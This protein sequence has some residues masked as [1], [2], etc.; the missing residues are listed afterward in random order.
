M[1][2]NLIVSTKEGTS[3]KT[4]D[5]GGRYKVGKIFFDFAVTHMQDKYLFQIA[6]RVVAIG[7]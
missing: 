5:N 1:A 6:L 7:E 4:D 3:I 2:L